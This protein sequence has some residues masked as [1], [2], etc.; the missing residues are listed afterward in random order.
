M[1]AGCHFGHKTSKWHPKME[2]YIF[3]QRNTV[4][5]I[6]L[7]KTQEKL[8]E[9]LEYLKNL[10]AEGKV[11]LFVG[12]KKQAQEI[13]GKY[14][15]EA[16]M[17]YVTERW[18]GGTITNFGVLSKRIKRMEK[19]EKDFESGEIKKYPKK[20]QAKFKEELERLQKYFGG[21]RT[22]KKTPDA[23]YIIGMR[24]AKTAVHEANLKKIPIV[25]VC[26]TNINPDLTD[27][28]IPSNDDAIKAVELITK[29]VAEAV[30]EGKAKP[31]E[32]AKKDK[33]EE[34]IKI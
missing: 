3:G 4:H 19:L 13:V 24:E 17:P 21:I 28:P 10:V 5:I 12:V 18:L 14:A 30:K 23:L 15:Q 8:K 20:E 1:E 7:E 27:Y 16:G 9:A 11:I 6:N 29:L 31:I 26:D 32:A 2:P 33:K 25:G 34:S 22:L